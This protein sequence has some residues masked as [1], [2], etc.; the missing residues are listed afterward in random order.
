VKT[1]RV[2]RE[3]ITLRLRARRIRLRRS[4]KSVGQQIGTPYQQIG[5]WERGEATP[6]LATTIRWARALDMKIT[7]EDR[8]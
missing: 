1:D 7:V 3:E 8:T 5:K 2:E 6:L 4:Q